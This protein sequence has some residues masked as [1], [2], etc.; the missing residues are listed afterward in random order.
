[1]KTSMTIALVAVLS[2]LA[3]PATGHADDKIL[4]FDTMT[5]VVRPF[6]GTTNPIRGV[7][8][9]GIPWRVAAAKGEL[10]TDGR[11]RVRVRGLV[12]AEGARAGTN[13]IT[14]FK[15]IVSCLTPAV[16]GTGALVASTVNRS[17]NTFP[18]SPEGDSEIEDVVSLPAPCIAPIVFVTSPTG[19]WFAATGF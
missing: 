10:R 18:A 7:N 16:D 13:P 6:T 15:A 5:G 1:M 17:T 3:M 14:E 9:G 12:L 19:S 4:S 11:I 8:G 2:L